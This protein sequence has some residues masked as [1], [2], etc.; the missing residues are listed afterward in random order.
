MSTDVS[1]FLSDLDAGVFENKV[2]RNYGAKIMDRSAIEAITE[3]P[4][5]IEINKY[6]VDQEIKGFMKTYIGRFAA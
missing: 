6:Q 4:T 3:Q 5:L 1:I 2:R